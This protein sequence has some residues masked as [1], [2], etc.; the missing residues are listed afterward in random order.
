[1]FTL[2]PAVFQV[3]VRA[4]PLEAFGITVYLAEIT[5]EVAHVLY[6]RRNTNR[7]I[8]LTQLN[9]IKRALEKLRW[10][11]NGETIIFDAEGRL[12]EGQHRIK[13]VLETG[14][15]LWSL[16]VVGIDRE[17]FKTMGQG[18]RR[19]AG[20][21]LGIRGAKNSRTLA[22]A[23]RWV[24]RYHNNL[25]MNPHPNLTDD[26]L[27]DTLPDH[28]ALAESI[29]FGTR[30]HA[31][32]APGLCTALHYLC[33]K[34]DLALANHFFWAFG[35]GENLAAGDPILILRR[36]F[37]TGL[38]KTRVAQYVLRD[39]QK[40]PVIIKT[41]NLIRKNPQ[42]RLLNASRIAWQGSRGERFP[43]IV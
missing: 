18:A 37:M 16:V 32:A 28:P 2:D 9:K 22:A 23:L 10:E 27:A 39:E 40:A 36:R 30:C 25:M 12:I 33:R 6:D 31:V 20:D 35:T 1:M 7:S 19:N 43:E 14:V 38:G 26:E 11:I 5:P 3:P 34:R 8:K 17:G 21:I 4:M 15:A 41:W 24:Y 42:V 13:G 29:P